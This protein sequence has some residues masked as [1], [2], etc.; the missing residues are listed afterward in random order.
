MR[1]KSATVSNAFQTNP[2]LTW[3]DTEPNTRNKINAKGLLYHLARL[4]W[5]RHFV[6]WLPDARGIILLDS[7]DAILRNPILIIL[8]GIL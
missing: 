8:T 3:K 2:L 7:F 6:M 4:E 5:R 1:C